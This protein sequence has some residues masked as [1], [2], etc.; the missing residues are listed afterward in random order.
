MTDIIGIDAGGSK[1]RVL[2]ASVA[3]TISKFKIIKEAYFESYSYRQDGMTVLNRLISQ[4]LASFQIKDMKS[5]LLLGGFAGAG[6][7]KSHKDIQR[8]FEKHGFR[9]DL[10]NIRSDADLLLTA[11]GNEG[12]VLT[13]GTGS[14][15]IGRR[16]MSGD[17]R[18]INVRAG[19]YGFR[20][21]SEPG[22]YQL[23]MR[24]VDAALKIEDERVQEPSV[25]YTGIKDYFDVVHLEEIIPL[26]YPRAAKN[27]NVNR[28]IA[29]IA[30]LVLK[31]THEG[32]K[33]A[34]QLVSELVDNFA[35]HIKAVYN[36]L[37]LKNPLVGLHGGLFADPYG[38][39]LL[40]RPLTQHELL[41]KYELRFV[42]LGT[43]KVDTDPLV[44][45]MKGAVLKKQGNLEL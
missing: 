26:I 8:T 16:K 42:T 5:T 11:I 24:A 1:T 21:Y 34:N 12:I 40:I 44:K 32:D 2:H 14:M 43:R 39:E 4:I 41:T 19:G 30:K 3:E 9:S 31:A 20:A 45:A 7:P 15:C 13:A 36:K 27:S 38:E 37:G 22:G 23:G 10:I 25:L 17:G 35:D 18:E 29:G 6:T 28:Q 33:T